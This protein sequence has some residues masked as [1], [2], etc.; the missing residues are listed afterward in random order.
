MAPAQR[1]LVS[2]TAS[3]A[4]PVVG[5]RLEVT[6]GAG[7]GLFTTTSADGSYRLYGVAGETNIRVTKQGHQPQTRTLAVADHQTFNIELLPPVPR[8]DVSGTYS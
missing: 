2:E 4:W 5:A 6:T 1:N 7:A 8:L 3:L